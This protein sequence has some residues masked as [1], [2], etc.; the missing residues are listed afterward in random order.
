MFKRMKEN[1]FRM[2]FNIA[3][4][5]ALCA[6]PL[7][8]G[9]TAPL[10]AQ[11]Q[12][13]P[14]SQD[15]QRRILDR[16]NQQLQQEQQRRG[17]RPAPQETRPAAA[18]P[19]TAE[20]PAAAP[21]V[22]SIAQRAAAAG[23]LVQLSYDNADL[24]EFI[25]QIAS[26]LAITPI[27]IDPE[28]KGSVTIHSSAPMPRE[29]V[30]SLFNLIL[31]N[32]NAALVKQGNVYQIVPMSSGLKKGLEIIEHLPP[33]PDLKP[34]TTPAAAPESQQSPAPQPG[35]AEPVPENPPNV[36]MTPFGAVT[37]TPSAA[38]PAQR[39]AAGA[40]SVPSAPAQGAR[41]ETAQSEGLATHVIHVEFVPVRDLI[42]PLK[43]FMTDGGVIMPYE[44]FNMLIVTDYG[45]SVTKIIQIVNLLDKAY[46]DPDLVEL[47][48]IKYN[49]AADVLEDLKKIFG[50]GTKDSTTGIS[51]ISLD[52]LNSILVMANSK[53]G[54]EEVKRWI[55]QLDATT[56]RNVQTFI[57]TVENS[58]ASN[59]ALILSVLYGGEETS[60]ATGTSAAGRTPAVG[61]GQQTPFGNAMG[62]GSS[63]TG[64]AM[65][66]QG[67][68]IFGGSQSS[69]GGSG[70]FSGGQQLGPRL[71]NSPTV[72]SQIFR[73][74]V[75]SG[76]QETV[77]M[78][79]DDLNNSLI[80]QAS[81]ADY[82][83][84]LETIKRMDVLPRQA[85]I[86]AR[87]FEVD[88]TDEF[89]FGVSAS[90]QAVGTGQPLTTA[91]TSATNGALSASTFAFIGN[92]RE[93]LMALTALSQKTKVRIIEAPSVLALDGTQAK[94]VVGS[95]VP[96]SGGTYTASTGS[97]T[98]SVQYRDTGVSLI[99]QPRIS[100]SGS[101][102]MDIVPEVSAQG[103][104]TT[105]GPT[106]TKTSVSTTLSVKDGETVAIA[107]LIRESKST[108]RSG[109]PFLSRIPVLGALFGQTK[110]T[111][112]RTELIIL[113]TPHVIKTVEKSQETSQ[114][115][116]DSLRNVRKEVDQYNQT[117]AND[118]EDAKQGRSREE[119]KEK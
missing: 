72:S 16:L 116:K 10:Q 6:L 107:G 115:L 82:A 106:F 108:S 36:I 34:K 119:Q 101:V 109:V 28:V 11:E 55:D 65:T 89:S 1:K 41:P 17:V 92:S 60:S 31:K 40:E 96:Y 114:R 90:L 27:V 118:L 59:I 22:P 117:I 57:Y 39:E 8:G 64:G 4:M 46:L 75:L 79:V 112:R 62:M 81:A 103:G 9:L 78:V 95:E 63:A 66:S 104:E 87:I 73:G 15:D 29:D 48:K 35:P 76:L 7:V 12:R 45:D 56:G 19:Q 37:R 30:F 93:I 68:G 5:A 52:R 91:S 47:I 94:I 67:S 98:S 44:R 85:I 113:I 25:N 32:N 42:E 102:T 24:L 61:G 84:L 14:L 97:T 69:S 58:T 38:A 2:S 33:E 23:G 110:T 74:G 105:L 21:A 83:Y 70:V 50:G 20:T 100:A 49:A 111:A 77:R 86:D 99:V 71:N 80:I 51:F 54:L 3:A 43:L 53:R 88:L 13:P 18:P 26:T